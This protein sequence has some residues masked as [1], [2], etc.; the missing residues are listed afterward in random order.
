MTPAYIEVSAEVRYWEDATIDGKQDTDGT[1]TP[2]RTGDNWCPVIRLADGVVMD[3]PTGTTADIHFKVCDAGL[4]WLLDENRQRIAKWGGHYVPDDFLCPADEGYGDYIILAIGGD[5]AITGWKQPEIEWACSC[6]DE[7]EA[8][9]LW[10]RINAQ[11][12]AA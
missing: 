9:Y 6:G 2:L 12:G 11:G 8:Q 7:D 3:W 10:Q 5:G 4:Y 1:L